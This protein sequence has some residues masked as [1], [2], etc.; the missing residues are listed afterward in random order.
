MDKDILIQELLTLKSRILELPQ[1]Y[2]TSSFTFG[3]GV[4]QAKDQIPIICS[5]ID[6]AIDALKKGKDSH[7]MPITKNQIADGL[8][9]LI[10]ATRRPQFIGLITSILNN[11]GIKEF[12][13]KI[14]ELDQI[15]AKIR[16]HQPEHIS[17][18]KF[19][20]K[21]EYIVPS[22]QVDKKEKEIGNL[23]QVDSKHLKVKFRDYTSNEQAIKITSNWFGTV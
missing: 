22:K 11:E 18:P 15:V 1:K 2:T 6:D 12:E 3:S 10:N 20:P 19:I 5:N 14:N 7:N 8:T 17:Q 9:N 21:T 23:I 13:K 4:A 16:K